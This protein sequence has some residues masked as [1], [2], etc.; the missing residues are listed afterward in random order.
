METRNPAPIVISLFAALAVMYPVLGVRA[1]E[2]NPRI[3]QKTF[4]GTSQTPSEE[5]AQQ[6]F[7]TARDLVGWFLFSRADQQATATDKAV[8]GAYSIEFLVATVPDPIDSRLPHFFDSFAESIGSAAEAAGYNLDRFALPWMEEGDKDQKSPPLWSQTL[9]ESVPGLILFR[10]PQEQRLLLVFLVGETPT[11]GIHKQAMFSALDQMAQFYPW[12]PR[13]AQLPPQFPQVKSWGSPDILRV[14]GPAFSGSAVSLRFVLDNWLESRKNITNLRFQII[15]GTATAIDA[16]WLSHVGH[17]QATFQ[18]TVP[19]DDET[20]QEVA[21]YIQ[22]LGYPRIAILTEGNT[23]YGQNL[24][25]DIAEGGKGGSQPQMIC[26]DPRGV[27]QI[28][29]LPFPLHISNLREASAQMTDRQEQK[30]S[31]AGGG[32]PAFAPLAQ[33]RTPKPREALPAFSELTGQSAELT[34]SNLLST[35]ARERYS[36]VGIVATD[37][38]DATFLVREVRQHCPATVLFAFNSDLLYAYPDV[39]DVTRGMLVFTPYPLFNLEQLWTYPYRGGE[40]RLQFSSQPAEGVYN[41]TLALLHRDDLMVD[42][43]GPLP[44]PTTPQPGMHKPSF[45]VTAI[46]N[47]ETLPVSLLRWDDRNGYMYS[48]QREE[49][50]KPTVGRGIY[51][52]FSVVVVIVLSLLLCAFSLLIISQYRRIDKKKG[53]DWISAL[54]GDPVSPAYWSEGRLFLVCCCASLLTFYVLVGVDFCLPLIASREL[55]GGV[56]TTLKVAISFLRVGTSTPRNQASMCRAAFL[57][58]PIATVT[59]RS[60]GTMSPPAKMPG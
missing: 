58:W 17:D 38:R 45:W 35:I 40:T 31:G 41:A 24:A 39:N 27:P 32:K 36:Y 34:L 21:C 59:V 7:P 29:D 53:V 37:V 2:S 3:P 14:M 13:H 18:A 56:Q 25:H 42:Y 54:L 8:G 43:G 15:S 4:R 57:P 28:L 22:Q 33:E 47:G 6:S 11:T 10:N 49:V 30:G 46:G 19:P 1:P 12:D 5:P 20:L 60:D 26:R 44:T 55:G 48:P 9:Y 23:A 52:E 51:G 50:G 16:S